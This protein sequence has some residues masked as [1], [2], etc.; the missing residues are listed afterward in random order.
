MKITGIDAYPLRS[1]LKRPFMSGRGSWYR[2]RTAL[3]LRVRTDEGVV[4]WG[5]AYGPIEV[6][7]VVVTKILAPAVEGCDP[8]SFATT[9]ERL[10]ARYR[11][12]D[13]QGSLI[14]SLGAID[15]A[16]WDLMG[17]AA[18]RPVHQLLGGARRTRFMPYA[19]GLYFKSEAG[20]HV[21]DAV[22]EAL[23]HREQ[24]FR[25][26]KVKVA[27]GPR[28]EARRAA[29]IR[30]A[31]G[32]D[33][34]LMADANHAY[35]AGGA[36]RLGRELERLGFLWF[37]EPVLPDDLDGY[38]RLTNALDME[39]AGGENLYGVRAFSEVIRQG[40]LDIVQPDLTAMGGL[41][42][43]RKVVAVA[44]AFGVRVIP[45]IWGTGIGTF[46]ALQLMAAI[47]DQPVTWQPQPLWMEYEQTDNPFRRQLLH[48]QLE[49][50]DGW[51][52]LPPGPGLGF[53]VDESVLERY[54]A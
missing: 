9:A 37:E 10:Y 42:E 44:Q 13:P 36:L 17:K 48:E 12:Y 47:P 32:D 7:H 31:V 20:D 50:R 15:I 23:S 51:V 46:A 30:Q 1:E 3:V 24:G 43:A 29:A 18:G 19:T 49:V 38:R 45:H 28:A 39:I 25:G 21:A 6:N 16:C 27:L 40:C 2:A 54:R 52:D 5:E 14:A 8:H 41:T 4:G 34:E 53:T 33:M 11:D 22:E 35:D 26:I